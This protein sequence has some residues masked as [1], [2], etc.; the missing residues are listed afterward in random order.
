MTTGLSQSRSEASW[1]CMPLSASHRFFTETSIGGSA[2][3]CP[4]LKSLRRRPNPSYRELRLVSAPSAI[5]PTIACNH[6]K[7]SL[8]RVEK[9]ISFVSSPRFLAN[10]S[11]MGGCISCLKICW[12]GCCCCYCCPCRWPQDH[13]H[14]AWENGPYPQPSSA[15]A[16]HTTD[17][18]VTIGN[19][20]NVA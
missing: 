18:K 9:L 4:A 13:A 12:W 19:P 1:A 8:L 3:L 6:N 16:I 20:M 14:D 7:V 11:C 5:S 17:P 15:P 2:H 10:I